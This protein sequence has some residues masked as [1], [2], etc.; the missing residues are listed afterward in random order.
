MLHRLFKL[1]MPSDDGFI[2][3]FVEHA[4][5]LVE[6]TDS[7][8]G[9][10][11]N[12]WSHEAAIALAA[13][14]QRADRAAEKVYRLLGKSFVTP[15]RRSEI[16]GLIGAMDSIADYA[17][18]VA[19][20]SGVYRVRSFPAEAAEMT[21]C[22]RMCVELIAE[23]VP[24]LSAVSKNAEAI[25]TLCEKIHLVEDEADRIYDRALLRLFDAGRP[26]DAVALFALEKVFDLIEEVVDACDD[27]AKVLGDIVAE[28]A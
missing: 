25:N 6:A 26:T 20:R 8:H 18:D 10:V 17:E 4:A 13:S 3:L 12:G 28:N 27:A 11:S 16:R 14:E 5:C 22:A 2:G 19:K 9:M 1:M 23:A 15:F 24:M 7:L 21:A